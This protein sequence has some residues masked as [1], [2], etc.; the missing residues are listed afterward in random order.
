M[1]EVYG[2]SSSMRTIHLGKDGHRAKIIT[3]NTIHDP[4]PIK[5]MRTVAHY[6]TRNPK[7]SHRSYKSIGNSLPSI[8][9]SSFATPHDFGVHQQTASL[10]QQASLQSFL[11]WLVANGVEGIGKEDSKAS[12]YNNVESGER[13]LAA[14][15]PL[16]S[17][18]V[19]LRVPL[20]LAITE[21]PDD[22]ESNEI[23][24]TGAAWSVRLAAKLL[25]MRD[26]GDACP[27]APYLSVLPDSVPSPLISFTWEDTWQIAYAPMRRKL[28]DAVWMAGAAWAALPSGAAGKSNP[29]RSDFDW[30]LSIVHSRTFGVA[31][32]GGGVGIRMLVPLIDM[33]NHAG[34]IVRTP[35]GAPAP[36]CEATDNVR[37]DIATKIGGDQIMVL[38]ATRD[39]APGEELL[40]SYGERSNE[41][42]FLFYGFVPPRNPHDAVS[43]FPSI[44]DAI[45]WH[46]EKYVPKGALTPEQLQ[47]TIAAAYGA[48]RNNDEDEESEMFAEVPGMSVADSEILRAEAASI[49]LLSGGRVD[50]RFAAAV[51][52]LHSAARIAGGA[53]DPNCQEHV[54]EAVA[55]RAGEI[56]RALYLEH[57]V[58]LD[59]DLSTLA[60][61]EESTAEWEG[62]HGFAQALAHYGPSIEKTLD[63]SIENS[64]AASIYREAPLLAESSDSSN[65]NMSRSNTRGSRRSQSS[66]RSCETPP[67]PQ[68]PSSCADMMVAVEPSTEIVDAGVSAADAMLF[69][70]ISISAVGG[71]VGPGPVLE[72]SDE[73]A[74]IATSANCI[75]GT[76]S[77]SEEGHGVAL[78]SE[79]GTAGLQ[80]LLPV[81]YRAYK[82]QILWDAVLS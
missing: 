73:S 79:S 19:I 56:L 71:N 62:C 11:G 34:D 51:A 82:C 1:W 2:A 58:A 77:P 23:M 63:M 68:R 5:Y 66:I 12:L 43:L 41:D 65:S 25:R 47:T 53:V 10:Q 45:D 46:L 32:C 31:A 35:F 39:I 21:H 54:R 81:M 72:V 37:W 70:S 75:R 9:Q 64:I 52:S 3:W 74:H 78:G 16:R 59:H 50:G 4:L 17:G 42:F 67:R 60:E 14:N 20:L 33:L 57:G 6:H 15:A 24:N 76:T 80:S 29:T 36:Q 30:A 38:S 7:F 18:E 26:Q 55:A 48:S 13:G 40:L 69:A 49:K 44:E 22:E 28:D 61:W 27:W 8:T